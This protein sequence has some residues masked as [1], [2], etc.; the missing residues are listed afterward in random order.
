MKILRSLGLILLV[1][2]VATAVVG[3]ESDD[4]D[5]TN[6]SEEVTQTF[7]D[8]LA[9]PDFSTLAAAL[10]AEDLVGT[11]SDESNS[12]TVFAPTNAAFEILLDDLQVTAADLLARDDLDQILLYHVVSG[13][14]LSTQ[15]AVGDVETLQGGTVAIGFEDDGGVTVNTANVTG[16][17]VRVVNGVVHVIDAVLL[18]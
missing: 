6:E 7:G 11:L 10:E 5:E 14:V 1:A 12:F 2:L 15:L 13:T 9:D 4:D 8:V 16:A 18:P 3:C 17:D